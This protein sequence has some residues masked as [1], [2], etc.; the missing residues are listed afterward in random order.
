MRY[1][2]IVW[3]NGIVHDTQSHRVEEISID[4]YI[5]EM[6]AHGYGL[7]IMCCTREELHAYAYK[8]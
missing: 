6:L 1:Y 5:R 7:D 8:R 4:T 2:V 3:K